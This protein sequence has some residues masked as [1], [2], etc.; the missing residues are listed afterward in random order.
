MNKNFKAGD[1]VRAIRDV[2]CQ[3]TGA[4]VCPKGGTK[5]VADGVHDTLW[6]AG[7]GWLFYKPNDDNPVNR[8]DRTQ[9]FELVDDGPTLAELRDK[10][11]KLRE[12]YKAASKDYLDKLWK[13]QPLPGQLVPCSSPACHS[14]W[15]ILCP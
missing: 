15:S 13:S 14:W 5:L 3:H 11:D 7:T 12:E 2:Y 4:L 1:K 9:F 8:V 6:L 10:R